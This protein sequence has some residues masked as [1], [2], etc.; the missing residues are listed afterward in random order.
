MADCIKPMLQLSNPNDRSLQEG[1]L[2]HQTTVNG[3]VVLAA[4][5][6]LVLNKN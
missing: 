5:E 3:L 6:L 2:L 4:I 1:L